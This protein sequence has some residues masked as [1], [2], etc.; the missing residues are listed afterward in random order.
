MKDPQIGTV[1]R[2]LSVVVPVYNE[3]AGLDALLA[4]TLPVC[5]AEFGANFEI[6]L[7]DD[8]SSDRSWAIIAGHAD[9]SPNIV[10]V[11]LS[12]NYGHQLALTAGLKLA[13]GD[14]V[15]VLD[16]D[17]QDPPE[18]LPQMLA[19][20]REGYDVVY[21][22]R[23]ARAGETVFKRA[24]ANLFYRLLSAMVD[25]SIPRDTG[26]FRLMTRRVV[27]HFNAM[28]E[29]FRFVRGMVGWLGFKQIAV[30][31]QR[32]A[33]FAGETHYP[34]RKMLRFATDAITSFST[35]PLRFASLLGMGFGVA[36]LLALVWVG[37]SWLSGGTVH[38]WTSLA[39]L[40]LILGSMQLLMLG[41]FGEY[42]GR[43][44]MESKQR[45]LYLVDEVYKQ[46]EITSGAV[47]DISDE[48]RRA[49]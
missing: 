21:G 16:A 44:Y 45:P 3:E 4:R 12:R 30:H 5:E 42:L 39:A 2:D 40:I 26:D 19:K 38:G 46:A 6:I 11:K 17:L 27:A 37:V 47:V 48:L 18:L 35:I 49:L 20:A 41:I 43:M 7:V 29:R 9:A 33:R 22:Q 10:G 13:R 28:P 14:Y 15:F 31:Y 23:I 8:G 36:G 24:T 34:L 25:V 32:D 1:K